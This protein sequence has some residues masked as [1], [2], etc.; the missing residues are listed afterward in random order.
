LNKR[1]NVGFP[2]SLNLTLAMLLSQNVES[3][4]KLTMPVKVG[5]NTDGINGYPKRVKTERYSV[6]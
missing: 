5:S 2:I 3:K 1:G 4:E 6:V